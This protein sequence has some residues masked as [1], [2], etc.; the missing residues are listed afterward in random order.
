MCSLWHEAELSYYSHKFSPWVARTYEKFTTV[1]QSS[2]PTAGGTSHALEAMGL[3][4]LICENKIIQKGC[5]LFHAVM[6]APISHLLSEKEVGSF[7]SGHAHCLQMRQIS[8]IS[9]GSPSYP[10]V[11]GS[12]FPFCHQG[13]SNHNELIQNALCALGY[14]FGPITIEAL[15]Q[16]NLTKSL[17]N[18][19][20]C[21]VY[22]NSKLFQLHTATLSFPSLVTDGSILIQLCNV[23]R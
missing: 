22:Q 5:H 9:P 3:I 13:W 19:S 17:F 12:S 11:L 7:S 18:H 14:T 2:T 6:Q 23:I 20:I 10:Q 21:Y 1:F 15:K 16:L 4:T 8:V